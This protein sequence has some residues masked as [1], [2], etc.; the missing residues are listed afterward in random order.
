[1]DA[2]RDRTMKQVCAC[3]EC[4]GSACAWCSSKARSLRRASGPPRSER[5]NWTLA[6][7]TRRWRSDRVSPVTCRVS[8]SEELRTR[9]AIQCWAIAVLQ[10]QNVTQGS[11][12]TSSSY[13][14]AGHARL[15]VQARWRLSWQCRRFESSVQLMRDRLC[16]SECSLARGVC[17]QSLAPA[18]PLLRADH[19]LI[20]AVS[21]VSAFTPTQ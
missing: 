12:T 19:L 15:S 3:N 11:R 6:A 8:W 1:M 2:I 13:G 14:I 9:I 18:E 4:S 17:W 16:S 7:Q 5:L 10:S 20:C 21:T